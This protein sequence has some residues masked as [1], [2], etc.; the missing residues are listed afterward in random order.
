MRAC[1]RPRLEPAEMR[2]PLH[3][4]A[5]QASAFQNLDVLGGRRERHRKWLREFAHR[6][7]AGREVAQHLPPR[8]VAERVK[9]GIHLECLKLNHV[10]KYRRAELKVNRMV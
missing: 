7:L 3:L 8:G 10:V 5:D 4:A 2:A 6:P 9:D 1:Q